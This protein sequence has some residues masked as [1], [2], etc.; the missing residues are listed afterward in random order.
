MEFLAEIERLQR[1]ERL[2]PTPSPAVARPRRG[3]RPRA[4]MTP[5]PSRRSAQ[6]GGAVDQGLNPGLLTFDVSQ[7]PLVTADSGSTVFSQLPPG[8]TAAVTKE[9]TLVAR[10]AGSTLHRSGPCRGPHHAPVRARRRSL[11]YGLDLP[12]MTPGAP[13][14]QDRHGKCPGLLFPSGPLSCER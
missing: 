4:P 6:R 5:D 7:Q 12:K 11:G 2:P 3:A 13:Q 10:P 1:S 9:A 14:G 8:T